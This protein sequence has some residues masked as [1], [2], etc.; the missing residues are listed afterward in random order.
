MNIK[1]QQ[2]FEYL[3]AV[4]NMTTPPTRNYREYEFF[5]QIDELPI[6]EGCYLFGEGEIKEAWLEIHK[7]TVELP[8][9]P[10][11]SLKKWLRTDYSKE[12]EV[13]EVYDQIEKPLQKSQ[14]EDPEI[15]N[16]QEDT[17]R[18]R[19]FNEWLA[20]WR[21]WADETKTKKAIQAIYGYFFTLYQRF[22]REGELLDLAIGHGLLSWNNGKETINHPLLITHLELIFDSQKG[23]FS[24]LP[25]EQGTVMEIE[26]LD[27]IDLPN[28]SHLHNLRKY[29]EESG[30]D[31]ADSEI[32]YPL[33][34]DI[35]HLLDPDG[36]FE[37][38]K[39]QKKPTNY[40]LI[41]ELPILFLRQKSGQLWKEELQNIINEIKQGLEVPKTLL[42]LVEKESIEQDESE[43]QEWKSV[44]EELLFPLPANE[45]Q[46]EIARRLA[47]NIGLTVQGPPGTGKSHTIAN[48]ISH[49]LAHGKRVL[50]TSHT[51]RAL[52]VL[53]NKIPEEIRSLCVSVLGGDARSLQEIEDSIRSITNQMASL[54]VDNLQKEIEQT[55]QMLKLTR[56]RIAEL[57]IKYR[58]AAEKEHEKITW[59]GEEINRLNAAKKLKETENSLSWLP[60]NIKIEQTIPL[61]EDELLRLWNLR[62]ELNAHEKEIV[63]Q[64]IPDI[65][66]LMIPEQFSH[67]VEEGIS[68]KQKAEETKGQI[69]T[70]KFPLKRSFLEEVRNQLNPIIKEQ[71]ILQTPYLQK[72]LE[73][74]LS[75]GERKN[76]WEEFIKYLN[77]A[78]TQISQLS[79]KLAEHEISLPDC[80]PHQLTDDISKI[81]SRLKQNKKLNGIYFL[82]TGR[83]HKYLSSHAIINKKPLQTLDEIAIVYDYL[84]FQDKKSKLVRMWNATLSDVEGPLLNES[85]VRLISNVDQ[86]IKTVEKIKSLSD[87]ITKLRDALSAVVFPAHYKWSKL[88]SI[89]Q[90]S[91]NLQLVEWHVKR[92][93]WVDS[94]NRRV[95]E[96]KAL[97]SKPNCHPIG[98]KLVE[99]FQYQKGSDWQKNYSEIA[100]L[101]RIKKKYIEFYQLLN[102]LRDVAPKWSNQIEQGLGKEVLYPKNWQEAWKWSQLNNWVCELDQYHPEAI[103]EQIQEE[104]NIE[105][106]LIE[107]L[108]AN[109]TW[110]NQLTRI[111]EPQKRALLAWKQKIK[112]IGKGTGKYAQQFRKEAKQE[113]DEA[114]SAIPVWIMPIDRVIENLSIK[115]EKFDVVIVDESSQCD[116]FALSALLR[117]K[118]AVVVGDDEQI[119]PAAVGINQEGVRSLIERYLYG[120]PQSNSLDMQASLYDVAGRLFSGGIMLKEHFRCVPEIIQFSNDLS[121]NGEIIPLRLPTDD[122]KVDPP[123]LA[124]RVAGYRGEGSKVINEVE[125]TEIVKDIKA[126]LED[127]RYG[128]VSIGVISLQGKDQA[129]LI[130]NMIRAEIPEEEIVRR[131]IICGDAYAFQG[132][133]RD[134]IFLSMVIAENIRFTALTK[135]DA[136]Q[137]FN[138]AAS[139]AKNQM[140]LYHS[141]D[142]S[143][144]SIEDIRFRLL[145]YCQNPMRVIEL[146]EEL[147]HLCESP[148][149]VDVLR[150][151]LAKGYQVRP[152]VKVGKYRIDLVVEGIKNRLAVECDGD[153]WHGV[154][155]WEEDMDRQR[156]LERAG[157]R[158]WRV[159]GSSFYRDRKNTMESLWSL[160]NELQIEKKPIEKA[161]NAL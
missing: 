53:T 118:K 1:V 139:R 25:K 133:E 122:E 158:F 153:R 76:T 47:N 142:L 157:W 15:E 44:G 51:E 117:A 137:R 90:F 16:F 128:H 94:F 17:S 146:V 45:D 5:R 141:I 121:Y 159:R 89:Q 19:A 21:I 48:L 109:S 105:R 130:E 24:L 161:S 28:I 72:I 108:V 155:K 85:Q 95:E 10:D 31:P 57:K 129:N 124:K 88:E 40:P 38:N 59:Q 58:E 22:Q 81:E 71:E 160:L 91:E 135:K 92:E 36:K 74:F 84:A 26:M 20:E 132:D 150:M 63:N 56:R 112:R 35:A 115:K 143:D 13:P 144:L 79:R 125:A 113:M 80:S 147:E 18:V 101:I 156:I 29:I 2:I 107:T 82:T 87:K 97:I 106:K 11:S 66:Q 4:K 134:I 136:Q 123:V 55:E 78:N 154:D 110:K 39:E 116:L 61:S 73:D 50:V 111:T 127:S 7:Q 67:W 75:G 60:D 93:Q 96:L 100:Y 102:R 64:V 33:Y 43:K 131:N 99:A 49:L 42:S 12:L 126:L 114:R 14:L 104:Q 140:R 149:E 41:M 77:E 69:S 148:F 37:T 151:I 52:R 68:L 152:Q 6:G 138:V 83:K 9:K 98:L 62:G 8:P 70:Y 54:D 34:K 120:I 119:S 145:H 30:I 23:I 27:G 3:L 86:F 46:K 32:T 65:G 103:E